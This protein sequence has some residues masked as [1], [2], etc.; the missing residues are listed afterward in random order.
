MDHP[1]GICIKFLMSF[2][3]IVSFGGVTNG[4]KEEASN[5]GLS[6]FSWEEFLITVRY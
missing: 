2:A 1:C 6:I 4:Q 5:H 3:V